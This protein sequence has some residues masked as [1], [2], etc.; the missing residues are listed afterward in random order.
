MP[1]PIEELMPQLKAQ[2]VEC[3]NMDSL[4]AS[5]IDYDTPLLG[6]HTGLDSIDALELVVWL[7]KTYGIKIT[8]SK[9]ARKILLNIRTLAEFVHSQRTL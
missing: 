8:D 3:L 1:D 2:I 9:V 4:V 5:T 6:P 7:D